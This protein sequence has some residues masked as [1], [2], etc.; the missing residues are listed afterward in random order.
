MPAAKNP[1]TTRRKK[2]KAA[3]DKRAQTHDVTDWDLEVFR[4]LTRLELSA[5]A[6][7]RL[8]DG[9]P[10][11]DDIQVVTALHWHPEM[12]A[13]ELIMQRVAHM[14][15][16]LRD[17]L[18]IPTDHNIIKTNGEFM[19]VEI[20]CFEPAFNRKVQFLAHFHIDKRERCGALESMLEHTFRYRSSQFFEYVDT[21][22][23]PA[24]DNRLQQAVAE[25]EAT[26]DTVAFVKDHVRKLKRLVIDHAGD[27]PS[28]MIKNK[29]V[30]NYFMRLTA[31]FDEAT[32]N[33]SLI[34]LKAVKAVV[35]RHFRLDYFFTAH[36]IIEEVR[37]IG[38][39]LVLPHPEQFWPALLADYDLDGIEV[40]NPQSNQFTGYLTELVLQRRLQGKDRQ[41]LVTMGDDC[42]FGEHVPLPEQQ[43]RKAHRQI[44]YQPAWKDVDVKKALARFG[45]SKQQMLNEYRERL[46]SA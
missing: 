6:T 43:T 26:P 1:T 2:A 24:L 8:V 19:G 21:V 34:L 5:E 15:P 4:E 37:G 44:G 28:F 20:D 35:K 3:A 27:V 39:G 36:E 12:V 7:K 31:H 38:G 29:L 32:V 40:W 13:V 14:Y 10:V 16:N 42:H 17:Q 30:S 11:Y 18:I 41:L 25:V 33:R 45:T 9:A 46:R 23:D 22:L